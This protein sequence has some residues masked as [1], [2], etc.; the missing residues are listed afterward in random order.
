MAKEVSKWAVGIG[1]QSDQ[2]TVNTNVSGA[3]ALLVGV[4]SGS[5]ATGILLRSDDDI[6]LSMSRLSEEAGLVPGSLS[7]FGSVLQSTAPVLT[8][9]VDMMGNRIAT[10]TPDDGDFDLDEYMIR[11]FAGARLIDTASSGSAT[12]Y[13][14]GSTQEY[15][16]V[17]VWRSTESWTLVGCTFDLSWS[18]VAGAKCQMTVVV[19]ADTV[20]YDN[21]E[22]FPTTS[23]L[24]AYGEQL[25]APP[26]W[27]SAGAS[28][29]SVTRGIQSATISLALRRTEIGDC[30]AATGII[31]S[32]GARTV[33]L[34]ADWY[35]DTTADDF[36]DLEADLVTT[37]SGPLR[38]AKFNLGQL[39]TAGVIANSFLFN[40]YNLEYDSLDEVVSGDNAVRRIT[41]RTIVAGASGDGSTA[42]TEFKI[43]SR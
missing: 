12:H 10:G 18:F 34:T 40:L 38:L 30:N 9:I 37:G 16:T 3:T 20:I 7:R 39:A 33:S 19:H 24:L 25:G 13:S 15:Q 1:V 23:L 11:L 42:N 21:T 27:E 35:V 22:V 14:F 8:F 36:L 4:A 17:K 5:G 32:E 28:L 6:S 43:L 31:N 26:I 29:D 41:G 2:A